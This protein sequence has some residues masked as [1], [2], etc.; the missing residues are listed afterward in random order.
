M[1]NADELLKR[2]LLNMKYD[3]K[4]SL[5]EN[6][7]S[8]KTLLLEAQEIPYTMN[9]IMQFQTYVWDVAEKSIP[10]LNPKET[11]VKKKQKKSILCGWEYCTK[12]TAV[13]GHWGGNT[14]KAWDRHKVNYMKSNPDWDKDRV[15][16]AYK[17]SGQE[18]PTTT[19]QIKNF[20]RWYFEEKE[21]PKK[22]S[23]G[24]YTTKLCGKP[25]SKEIA[26]DGSWGGNT[27]TLWTN[28]KD[29]YQKSN[30]NWWMETDWSAKIERD[31]KSRVESLGTLVK[32]PIYEIINVDNPSGYNGE[33][34]LPSQSKMSKAY[35][36]APGKPGSKWFTTYQAANYYYLGWDLNNSVFP[37]PKPFS[38][39]E[40]T[41]VTKNIE[42]NAKPLLQY[43]N[44]SSNPAANMDWE[45]KTRIYG[46]TETGGLSNTY[47]GNIA[48][49]DAFKSSLTTAIY[50][51]IKEIG[52]WNELLKNQ[53]TLIPQY[54][55]PVSKTLKFKEGEVVKLPPGSPTYIS[56]SR[57]VK[58][59]ETSGSFGNVITYYISLSE[60]CQD[61]GGLWVYEDWKFKG[62]WFSEKADRMCGCRYMDN[63]NINTIGMWGMGNVDNISSVISSTQTTTEHSYEDYA[64]AAATVAE[65]GLAI[66][67]MV[68]TMGASAGVASTTFLAGT[69][70]AVLAQAFGATTMVVGGSTTAGALAANLMI[71][72]TISGVLD[73]SAYYAGGDKYMG[74]M[75]MA[76]SL[77]PG[78]EAIS[79]L[80]KAT[81]FVEV[82]GKEG[83]EQLLKKK[84]SKTLTAEESIKLGKIEKELASN[85][86]VIEVAVNSRI[87]NNIK[88]NLV[89]VVKKSKATLKDVF[90]LVTYF[91]NKVGKFP[92]LVFQLGASTYGFDELYLA[93]YGRDEDRQNS[94]IR[95]LYYMLKNKPLPE[96]FKNE[97]AE[98]AQQ[99]LES[100]FSGEGGLVNFNEKAM[101][102][103]MS[104]LTAARKSYNRNNPTNKI[105]YDIK[106]EGLSTPSL[107]DVENSAD[108]IWVGM[109]GNSVSELQKI[110]QDRWK[111]NG[112]DK[113][114]GDEG[115]NGI[116]DKRMED[117]IKK[118]QSDLTV[119]GDLG[120]M[121]PTGV[122]DNITLNYL[123]NSK[124]N[125]SLK[126]PIKK[127]DP[128]SL[129]SDQ[130]N[131]FK[132]SPR[133]NV[134]D[135]VDYE[136]YKKYKDLGTKVTEVLK[137]AELLTPQQKINTKRTIFNK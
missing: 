34:P 107:N 97:L 93:L 62:N 72:S 77:I 61:N 59:G 104:V 114:L 117:L 19:K 103:T 87:N 135:P 108:M 137:S 57:T 115:V 101:L 22:G 67:S 121:K 45:T 124:Q 80:R 84:A 60:I 111:F 98:K 120:Q 102:D 1:K 42:S 119:E 96:D 129:N 110:I 85:S 68:L 89:N 66:A 128:Y 63:L 39:E 116:Y 51:P 70:S 130:Y 75:M 65:I 26:I 127:I 25:C 29:Q 94:D 47:Q 16:F 10:Y 76:L 9:Q 126:L 3:P 95:K 41:K 99:E 21:K 78:G 37:Y 14:I 53:N 118:F 52:E 33:V 5:N 6:K 55:K 46:D 86:K 44:S 82:G 90:N 32:N 50:T 88:T 136:T 13:D 74:G 18:I 105:I 123:K 100:F 28:N 8:S 122:L 35:N 12:N 106:Y 49:Q 48:R 43:A 109:S 133:R 7:S 11:N 125:G 24:L 36:T 112:Y 81:N 131:F 69:E 15:D 73:A 58:N 134:W 27:K 54:C 38:Q 20:Q 92:T 132:W 91:Y 64:H 113:M 56:G 2:I 4:M 30:P 23:N 40:I 71:G 31:A 83:L 17:V 79:L